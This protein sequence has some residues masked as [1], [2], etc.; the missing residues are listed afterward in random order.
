MTGP[1]HTPH[2]HSGSSLP[3]AHEVRD[4]KYAARPAQGAHRIYI[5]DLQQQDDMSI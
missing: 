4:R 1:K 3:H 5:D 2:T